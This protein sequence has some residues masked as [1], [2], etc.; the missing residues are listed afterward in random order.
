MEIEN[1]ELK[2]E[3]SGQNTIITSLQ[4]QNNELKEDNQKLKNDIEIIMKDNREIKQKLEIIE[5]KMENF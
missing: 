5:K 4:K 1:L 3:L 2:K